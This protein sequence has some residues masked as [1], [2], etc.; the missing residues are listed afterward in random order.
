MEPIDARARAAFADAKLAKTNLFD[1]PRMFVDV[2][3]LLPGQAQAPHRHDDADKMYYA[4][5]GDGLVTIG[6]REM[7]LR[8]GEVAVCPAGLAHGVRALDRK[9]VLLVVM[10]RAAAPRPKDGA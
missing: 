6:E 9:L 8:A 10:A 4:L 7:P 3:G 1:S 5:E 2:Y